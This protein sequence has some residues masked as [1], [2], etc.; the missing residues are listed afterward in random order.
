MDK[1]KLNTDISAQNQI[2]KKNS[3]C[4]ILNYGNMQNNLYVYVAFVL[5]A[6]WI[7]I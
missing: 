2:F 4:Y 1:T 6:C 3:T 7:L 5:F